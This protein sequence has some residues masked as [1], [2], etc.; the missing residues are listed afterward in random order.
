MFTGP[1]AGREGDRSVMACFVLESDI[2]ERCYRRLAKEKPSAVYM[3][4]RE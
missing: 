3:C 4:V 2:P 1:A